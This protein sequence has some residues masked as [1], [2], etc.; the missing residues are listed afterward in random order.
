MKRILM[1]GLLAFTASFLWSQE[2]ANQNPNN[3]E[4]QQT[5]ETVQSGLS[6]EEINEIRQHKH[7]LTKKDLDNKKEGFYLTGLPLLN[8]DPDTGVGYGARVYFFQNGKKEDPLFA[9][10][11]YR[12]RLFAQFFQTTGGWNYHTIDYDAPYFLDSLFRLRAALVYEK[13]TNARYFGVGND[14]LHNLQDPS[15]QQYSKYQDFLDSIR[16]IDNNG[17]TNARFT[18]YT[19][20]NPLLYVSGERDVA[21]FAGGVL[22]PLV[23]FRLNKYNITD[24]TGKKVKVDDKDAIQNPTLLYYDCV[25]G[26]LLGCGGGWD[27]RLAFGIA[28]DSRDFEPD[29]NSGLFT[30]IMTE[31]ANKAYGADFNYARYTF[32]QKVYFSPIPDIADLVLA[33]R[34]V[35][36]FQKGDVPFYA[37]NKLS[38]TEGNKNG[39]GG[40][41]TLRGFKSNRFVGKV[42]ALTNFEIRWT[43]F[44][45]KVI[46]Q[47]F[48][49]ILV[50]F[51]D[52]GRVFNDP[53][54]TSFQGWKYDYGAGLRIAWNQATIIMIDYAMSSEDSGLFINFSHIF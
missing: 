43:M 29:P 49:F 42:M 23:A 48:A 2:D 11:P 13:N 27:N 38:F 53:K 26:K 3:E 47:D 15:G 16:K 41:R 46:G 12:H 36:S 54:Q 32:S 35:Y 20:E 28:F 9:Y 22:R 30:E 34:G 10:T 14:T 7:P 8:S 5:I 50:P 19:F 39:L 21:Y 1:A 31:I 24:Y 25:A 52:A 45:A 17:N 18:S 51:I 33:W 40:L 44:H 6:A 4:V 37:L